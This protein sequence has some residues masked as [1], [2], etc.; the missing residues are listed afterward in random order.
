[1]GAGVVLVR[2]DPARG[3]RREGILARARRRGLRVVAEGA[4]SDAGSDAPRWDGET[5]VL[6][7]A[8][9]PPAGGRLPRRRVD[10]VEGLDAV[11]R[12]LRA[13]EPV[14]VEWAHERVLPLETLVAA[15]AR[16]GTLWVAT[17]RVEDVP[18]FLGALEHGADGVV[19][20]VR[21]EAALDHLEGILERALAPL[22]WTPAA[23]VRVA[24][25]GLGDRVIVDT[26]SLL[27]PEE[28]MLVGSRAA[29]LLGVAS[30]AVGSKFTRP[31]PFRVNAGAPHQYTLLA[32]GTTRYLS[33]L[34]PG[35]AVVIAA[36]SGAARA[37]RVGRLKIER[38]PLAHLTVELRGRRSTAF[39]QEAET[40]RLLTT[41]GPV[42]V[43]DLCAGLHL[44]A[45]ELPAGRHLGHS[46][47]ETVDER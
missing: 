27:G 19:L 22:T 41:E 3:T 5:L 38:R 13:G 25:A 47:D 1:V 14:L 8:L 37:V 23:L 15:R 10:S 31:R 12:L 43:T 33:E 4:S 42:A 16:P 34:E 35:D 36:P 2:A 6:P 26:T 11:A 18:T 40:V 46:V 29:L 24:P 20:L 39:L 21:E 32:D 30:E 7:P 17:D 45:V 28:A 44:T 9:L